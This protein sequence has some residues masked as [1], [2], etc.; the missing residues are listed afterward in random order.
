MN[1]LHERIAAAL[2]WSLTDV[3]SLSILSL[4]EMVRPVSEKLAAELTAMHASGSHI[5]DG[6]WLET[7]DGCR[8]RLS[9]LTETEAAKL[10]SGPPTF[11]WTS[12][13]LIR[14]DGGV[15]TVL[16]STTRVAPQTEA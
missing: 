10:V 7:L 14:I 13:K 9:E 15:E 16:A 2:G 4:R 11:P 6:L 5:V 3:Q 8:V 1:A 12:L